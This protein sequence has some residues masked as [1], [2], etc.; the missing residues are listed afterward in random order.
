MSN[1]SRQMQER[2]LYLVVFVLLGVSGCAIQD[3]AAGLGTDTGMS[4]SDYYRRGVSYHRNGQYDQAISDYDKALEVAKR[5]QITSA[6]HAFIYE[7]RASAYSSKGQ[8]EQAISDFSKALEINPRS[9]LAYYNRGIVYAK[10]NQYDQAI[11]D[12]DRAIEVA[13]RDN[14][15]QR[16]EYFLAFVNRGFA[17]Q[18]KGLYERS[19]SDFDKAKA[20]AHGHAGQ[21]R[22]VLE[23]Y[24]VFMRYVTPT[25]NAALIEQA[26]ER[27]KELEKAVPSAKVTLVNPKSGESV[28]CPTEFPREGIVTRMI[29]REQAEQQRAWYTEF[30][31]THNRLPTPT[32]GCI[33]EHEIRG[34]VRKPE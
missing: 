12:Y 30:Q 29:T 6:Q 4:A 1:M 27:I 24:K 22:E 15:T 3:R 2:C 21:T 23:A 18:L 5:D 19:L 17:Y 26:R 20:V 11:S 16:R 31:R 7:N 34:F 9:L 33:K 14:L 32:E 28:T 13:E 10:T 25:A 8:S